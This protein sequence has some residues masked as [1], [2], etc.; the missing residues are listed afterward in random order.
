MTP[1]LATLLLEIS[2][3]YNRR[4]AMYREA[5][6]DAQAIMPGDLVCYLPNALIREAFVSL[7]TEESRVLTVAEEK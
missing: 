4:Q 7:S 1:A 5:A 6:G 2:S 3:Q